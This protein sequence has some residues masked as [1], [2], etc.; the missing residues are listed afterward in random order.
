MELLDYEREHLQRL[1]GILAECMVLLKTNGDFPVAAPCPVALY[2]GA[3]HTIKGGTGSGEVNSRYFITVEEG[4]RQAGFTITTGN[5]LNAYDQVIAQAEKEFIQTIKQRARKNHSNAILD[6]MGAIMPEPEYALPLEGEGDTAIYVLSRISGEGNDREIAGG[7]VL[8]SG[9]E[10]RDILACRAKY[11]RFLLVL[12]VGGPVDLSPVGEVENMLVLS[13]LGVETGAA[14]ADVLLGRTTPSGKLTTTWSSAWEYPAIGTFGQRDETRYKEGVYVGYRY[15]DSVGKKPMFPFGYGLSYTGFSLGSDLVSLEGE[16]VTVQA[17]VENIG[18]RP[19]KEVA[20]LYV[21]LP[22]KKLDQPYQSLAAFCKSKELNPGESQSMSLSFRLSD[23]AGFSTEESAYVLEEGDYVLR[24]GTSSRETAPAAVIR[25]EERVLVRHVRHAFD[26]PDFEDW[27]P[28]EPVPVE[29]PEN[30]PFLTVDASAIPT[31]TINYADQAEIDPEIQ[32]L[33][34]EELA[35][36]QIGAFDPKGGPLSVIGNAAF[37]VA[38]AAGET[39]GVL[40][41]K[42]IPAMVMADGPAGIRISKDYFK[43]SKGVHAIGPSLPESI[44]KFLPDYIAKIMDLTAKKPRKGEAVLHQYCTAIP[45]GTAI[46]QSWNLE[47][48]RMCGDLVG[49]E[50]ERFGI[51]LWLAPALNIHRDIRCGRNFEYFSEDPL[52]SGSFAAAITLG[53]QAHPGCGTTIKHFAA[54]NQ[55][56]NRYY[57][58]SQVSERAMR[59]IYLKGFEICVRAAQPHALMTSYNLLNGQHTSE[60]RDLTEDVLR[61]EWGYEGIV[62]TDWVISAMPKAKGSIYDKPEPWKVAAA[63]G[64]LYM[65]G[66]KS[67]YQNVLKALQEGRLTRQQAEKNGTRTLRMAKKLMEKANRK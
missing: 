52:I 63:G 14:L 26:H 40:K 35:Y 23:L 61:R 51:Q 29:I 59:E 1:R 8:L 54:N 2:G 10:I 57:S 65:P 6:S 7:D 48:A 49:D 43:D 4:L 19:G 30:V 64:D 39:T 47:L 42:G 33:S 11:K 31:E 9:P 3:R 55:E 17:R 37:G 46:A 27:R 24:L 53:V 58:N 67:D 5:W 21:S 25:L 15:F 28:E 36:L 50:M 62:M 20:Q 60:R 41:E 38:G 56:T 44:A 34:N 66:G 13:Q 18:Q 32:A 16:K 22:G 45:I 12:N